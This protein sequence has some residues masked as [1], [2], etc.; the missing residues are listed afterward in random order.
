MIIYAYFAPASSLNPHGNSMAF[1]YTIQG[2]DQNEWEG[3]DDQL[4]AQFEGL[5]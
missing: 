1:E 4:K 3:I 2:H 5:L